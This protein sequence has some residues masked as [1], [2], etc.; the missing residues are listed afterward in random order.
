[1]FAK[2]LIQG[3]GVE[4]LRAR[5]GEDTKK[6]DGAQCKIRMAWYAWELKLYALEVEELA[7]C[8]ARDVHRS[9]S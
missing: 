7:Y 8:L 3:F 1:M 9:S 2:V 6:V 4:Y 5:N